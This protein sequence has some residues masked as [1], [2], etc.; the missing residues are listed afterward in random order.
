MKADRPFFPGPGNL[1]PASGKYRL[2]IHRNK[3][4]DSNV[5]LKRVFESSLKNPNP[6]SNDCWKQPAAPL[7]KKAI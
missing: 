5:Y 1:F 4:R 6:Q 2:T 3:D 7:P